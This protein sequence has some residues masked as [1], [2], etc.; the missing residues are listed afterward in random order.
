MYFIVFGIVGEEGTQ[1]YPLGT[2]ATNR[3]IVPAPGH[4]SDGEIG[5]M[6]GRVT[7]STRRKP[8]PVPLCASQIPHAAR[9]RTRV[10]AVGSQLLTAQQ[11]RNVKYHCKWVHCKHIRGSDCEVN[12]TANT[13]EESHTS[14]VCSDVFP[15]VVSI[16]WTCLRVML[17]HV[18]ESDPRLK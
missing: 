5:G 7:R 15:N 16:M 9:T 10:A 13:P 17:P 6:I 2:T 3:P 8:A 12:F 1:L 4:Y 14:S 18:G 11:P